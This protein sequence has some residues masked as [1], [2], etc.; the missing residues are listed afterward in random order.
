MK[1]SNLVNNPL[2]TT[3]MVK[4]VLVWMRQSLPERGIPVPKEA[5]AAYVAAHPNPVVELII[6]DKVSLPFSDGKLLLEYRRDSGWNGW[7]TIGGFVHA[8]ETRHEAC[9]RHAKKSGL[10]IRVV[11]EIGLNGMI[12]WRDDTEHPYGSDNN[13]HLCQDMFLCEL[14]EPVKETKTL[15]W[16]KA[17]ENIGMVRGHQIH[18]D[19]YHN[20]IPK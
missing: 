6:A 17:S 10:K 11:V 14:I 19:A 9:I 1:M 20:Y 3:T 2:V 18:R 15:R 12:G 16:F 5:F 7:H 8:G 13:G 4:D